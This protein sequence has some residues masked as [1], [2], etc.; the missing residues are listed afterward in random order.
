MDTKHQLQEAKTTL[1]AS[2]Q[3]MMIADEGVRGEV[4]TLEGNSV[5]SVM[6]QLNK[7]AE[8]GVWAGAAKSIEELK[9]AL[10]E[11]SAEMQGMGDKVAA[12]KQVDTR[13]SSWMKQGGTWKAQWRSVGELCKA[14]FGDVL[15]QA[16][17]S[18]GQ[19][20][21]DDKMVIAIT[22]MSELEA[23]S[24]GLQEKVDAAMME[25]QE[26]IGILKQMVPQEETTDEDCK[27]SECCTETNDISLEQTPEKESSESISGSPDNVLDISIP[28]AMTT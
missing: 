17:Y 22:A 14:V 1:E 23:I 13:I 24:L 3:H 28:I 4:L 21:S 12:W 8:V 27:E 18:V 9:G 15:P 20:L 26:H 6:N 16:V 10:D 7:M 25:A 11:F 19:V 5:A 2:L